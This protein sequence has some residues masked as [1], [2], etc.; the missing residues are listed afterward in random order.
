M[1]LGGASMEQSIPLSPTRI[2]DYNSRDFK[3]TNSQ[4]FL[5]VY[6]CT[7][8]QIHPYAHRSIVVQSDLVYTCSGACPHFQPCQ[9][10]ETQSSTLEF[11]PRKLK[12]TDNSC[13]YWCEKEGGISKAGIQSIVDW[14]EGTDPKRTNAWL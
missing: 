3:A 7:L 11:F 14:R 5:E 6:I 1:N 12:F 8:T 2:W 4:P 13:S 9:V 10:R